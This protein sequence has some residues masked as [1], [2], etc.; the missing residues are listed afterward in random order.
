MAVYDECDDI[1]K[2][3][4]GKIIDEFVEPRNSFAQAHMHYQG[5][6]YGAYRYYFEL[7]A[8]FIIYKMS[9]K[10]LFCEEYGKIAYEWIY[11][12]RADGQHLRVG[13]VFAETKLYKNQYWDEEY[14]PLL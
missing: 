14:M 6:S 10:H 4:A 7:W 2:Y 12:R 8:E 9:G 11:L 3:C 5:S 13:D 1:Y